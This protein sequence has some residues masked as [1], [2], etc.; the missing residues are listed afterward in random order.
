MTPGLFR[1]SLCKPH[2]HC[3]SEGSAYTGMEVR[4]QNRK[5][6]LGAYPQWASPEGTMGPSE[7]QT[8]L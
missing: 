2:S 1:R 7:E 3:S 4:N 6:L 5:F 8:K